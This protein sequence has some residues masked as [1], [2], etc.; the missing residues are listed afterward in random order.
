M[1]RPHWNWK[2]LKHEQTCFRLALSAAQ[3]LGA[4]CK[5]SRATTEPIRAGI[6]SIFR[7]PRWALQYER[8]AKW[9]YAE[10]TETAIQAHA[11]LSSAKVRRFSGEGS[12]SP[13]IWREARWSVVVQKIAAHRRDD[14]A[15]DPNKNP[16]PNTDV[17]SGPAA[18][19][20]ATSKS[21]GARAPGAL[22]AG[23]PPH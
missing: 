10:F 22:P 6:C 11:K 15:S 17:T 1:I 3:L 4:G 8:H 20:S 12:R 14:Q 16:Q 9:K 7:P 5:R 19:I 2:R 23:H 13:T 18:L 21:R